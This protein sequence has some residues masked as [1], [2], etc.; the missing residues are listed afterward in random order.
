MVD[1]NYWTNCY[2]VP[3]R[4]FPDQSGNKYKFREEDKLNCWNLFFIQ[5]NKDTNYGGATTFIE[6]EVFFTPQ[7]YSEVRSWVGGGPAPL[8]DGP[9]KNVNQNGYCWDI[10]W[11]WVTLR[12]V[13]PY[14]VWRSGLAWQKQRK[15]E[16]KYFPDCG[17]DAQVYKNNT[18]YLVCD[19]AHTSKVSRKVCSSPSRQ[20]YHNLKLTTSRSA[21]HQFRFP[22]PFLPP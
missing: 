18:G 10:S 13:C 2:N 4:G 12:A 9:Y 14:T 22:F 17:I 5:R 6:W 8:P 16:L 15:T 11:D 19:Q 1:K 21:Y 7:F 20:K 3:G